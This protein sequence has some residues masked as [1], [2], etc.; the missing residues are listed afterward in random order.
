LAVR[1]VASATD[2][3]LSQDGAYV[4]LLKGLHSTLAPPEASA[5][6]ALS[7]DDAKASF[8]SAASNAAA[9]KTKA[10]NKDKDKEKDKAVVDKSDKDKGK[11]KDKAVV[12]KTDK[13]KE[14]GEGQGGGRQERQEQG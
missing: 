3:L 2:P 5:L 4:D 9:A 10:N 14:K 11:E 7:S 8:S 1:I 6:A 12:D 13:D